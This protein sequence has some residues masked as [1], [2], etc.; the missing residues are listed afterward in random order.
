MFLLHLQWFIMEKCKEKYFIKHKKGQTAT[1]VSS[2]ELPPPCGSGILLPVIQSVCC[3]EH[4]AVEFCPMVIGLKGRTGPKMKIM[5]DNFQYP[6][7]KNLGILLE[8]CLGW[9]GGWWFSLCWSNPA[10]MS[11][12]KPPS[13]APHVGTKVKIRYNVSWVAYVSNYLFVSFT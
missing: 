3:L 12:R 4:Q 13:Q 1:R 5:E 11:Y 8:S 7:D 2:T 6:E 9:S 10:W